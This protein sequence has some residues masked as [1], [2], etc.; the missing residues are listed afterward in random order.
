VA[1]AGHDGMSKVQLITVKRDDDGIRLDRWFKRHYPKVSHGVI[2]KA[3]R[4]GQIRL[5]GERVKA[6]ARVAEGQEIRV[7][8]LPEKTGDALPKKKP[9]K[10]HAK[11][12]IDEIRNAVIY[13]DKHMIVINK[14]A[15]LAVQGGTGISVSVDDLKQYLVGEGESLP[16][17]VHRLDK[18]TSG[19][20][21]LAKDAASAAKLTDSFRNRKVQK[22]YLAIVKGEPPK[23]K[24]GEIRL[25][26]FKMGM[27]GNERMIVD[28]KEGQ[29]AKTLYRIIDTLPNKLSLV[30]LSPV[31]GRTHQLRAHM[32]A[33]GT[34]ILADGKYGG[35]EAFVNGLS[36][37]MSLHAYQIVLPPVFGKKIAITAELPLHMQEN[38]DTLG[39]EIPKEVSFG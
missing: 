20:L 9:Q 21:V 24:E 13:E 1:G 27:V 2:E 36:K 3:L 4:K 31:T 15:G 35:Q 25:P 6:S 14:P 5:G 19:V 39:F 7:P 33:L 37:K 29:K 8:P 10:K 32:E 17:L 12:E 38:F 23:K 30:V 11:K 16:K 22:S 28:H 26:L 34:P 18:D